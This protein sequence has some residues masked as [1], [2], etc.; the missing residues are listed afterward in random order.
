MYTAVSPQEEG[1][2]LK[3][4]QDFFY[5]PQESSVYGLDHINCVFKVL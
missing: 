1:I 5:K 3:N 2:N 4:H